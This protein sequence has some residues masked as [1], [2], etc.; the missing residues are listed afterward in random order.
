[1]AH[2]KEN[3]DNSITQ[4][5][6]FAQLKRDYPGVT[7]DS[8]MLTNP[9]YIDELATVYKVFNVVETPPTFDPAMQEVRRT[10]VSKVGEEYVQQYAVVASPTFLN[11]GTREPTSA[12][13][14]ANRPQ[15]GLFY[16]QRVQDHVDSVAAQFNFGYVAQ[17]SEGQRYLKG[18]INNIAKY[19]NRP[20]GVT[21]QRAKAL[22]TWNDS[23]WSLMRTIQGQWLSNAIPAPTW[24]QLLAQLPAPPAVT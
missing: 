19:L 23:V 12:E 6:T 7:F 18:D 4:G 1:M 24:A 3:P 14:D 16:M 20:S 13:L 9:I 15:A 2:I 21:A 5:Y 22:E 10:V 17:T 8:A 11:G